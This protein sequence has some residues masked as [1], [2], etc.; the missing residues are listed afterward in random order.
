MKSILV[1][2]VAAVVLVGCGN[3]IQNITISDSLK[4]QIN[5]ELDTMVEEWDEEAANKDATTLSNLYSQNADIIHYDNV[6]HKGRASIKQ[7]F[8]DQFKNDPNLK[9]SF[10][11]HQRIFLSPEIVIESA[12]SHIIGSKM[13]PKPPTRGRYTA[14]Y[15]KT[16][17]KWLI[18]YER[19]WWTWPPQT[20]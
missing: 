20:N 7:Y 13:D 14:T 9:K 8:E 12:E 18:A 6:H 19:A 4:S 11:E 10:S 16:K 2:I 5:K 3:S 17:G 15:V 1:S